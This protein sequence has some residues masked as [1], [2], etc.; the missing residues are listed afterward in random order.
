MLAVRRPG[1]T[2]TMG[3]LQAAGLVHHRRGRVL[4]RDRPGL[5]GATCGCYSRVKAFT[6]TLALRHP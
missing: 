1:V 3:A 4:I 5:E 6:A 2:V